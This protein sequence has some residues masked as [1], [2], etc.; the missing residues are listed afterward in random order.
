M[1]DTLDVLKVS[2]DATPVKKK[3]K[4]KGKRPEGISREAYSLLDGCHPIVQTSHFKKRVARKDG[5]NKRR[6][7]DVSYTVSYKWKSFKNEA[8][9]DGLELKR[10]VKCFVDKQGSHREANG[11]EYP[12]AKLDKP[13]DVLKYS[14]VE[15]ERCL[16]GLSNDWTRQETDYLLDLCRQ[17]SLRFPVIEDRYDFRGRQRSYEEVKERYYTMAYALACYRSSD[18]LS[19]KYLIRNPYDAE[20]ERKRRQACRTVMEMTSEEEYRDAMILE[21]AERIETLRLEGATL[22]PLVS[23]DSSGSDITLDRV[24]NGREELETIPLHDKDGQPLRP[25][26]GIYVRGAFT[27]KEVPQAENDAERK[28]FRDFAIDDCFPTICNKKLI[29]AWI[30]LRKEATVL[31]KLREKTE[32]SSSKNNESSLYPAC[33]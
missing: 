16:L 28:I 27:R 3:P 20:Y 7:V 21:E 5:I 24:L 1:E 23:S 22:T 17:F 2:R 33:E 14:D 31:A 19:S 18:E 30:Q 26:P 10:W 32:S 25:S 13:A 8:R 6:K 4:P 11:V 15:W 9:K 12:F 29:K